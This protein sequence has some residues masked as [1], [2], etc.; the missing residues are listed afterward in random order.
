MLGRDWFK[1]G[2]K[3]RED[4]EVAAEILAGPQGW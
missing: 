2:M 1:E 4:R 3:S